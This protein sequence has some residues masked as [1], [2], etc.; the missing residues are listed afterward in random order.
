VVTLKQR[1]QKRWEIAMTQN[2]PNL[3]GQ[4]NQQGGGKQK[5]DQQNQQPNQKPGQG[6][7]QGGQGNPQK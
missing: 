7:Q 2:N 6:A 4:Q 1:L 5:P 3:G